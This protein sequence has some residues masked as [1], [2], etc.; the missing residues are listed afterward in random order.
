MNE[1]KVCCNLIPFQDIVNNLNIGLEKSLAKEI[2]ENGIG[3]CLGIG[4]E[5]YPGMCIFTFENNKY[6]K[7]NKATIFNY[8]PICGK[9]LKGR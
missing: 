1:C 4:K 7:S 9:I 6:I 2:Q 8:C 5:G 3:Y